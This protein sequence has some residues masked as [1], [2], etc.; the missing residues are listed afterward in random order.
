MLPSGVDPGQVVSFYDSGTYRE[1]TLS[2]IVDLVNGVA[3]DP[4]TR[5]GPEW[6]RSPSYAA[7]YF[8]L[9]LLGV[10]DWR[11]DSWDQCASGPGNAIS[12]K[13]GVNLGIYLGLLIP[14]DESETTTVTLDTAKKTAFLISLARAW[15]GGPWLVVKVEPTSYVEGP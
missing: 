3:A 5:L 12:D 1:A 11:A 8:T 15:P 13:A 10:A 7:R 4:R 2:E 9:D 6:Y 14:D